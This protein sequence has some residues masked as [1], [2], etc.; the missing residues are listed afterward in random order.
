MAEKNLKLTTKASR[1]PL[2]WLQRLNFDIDSHLN[3]YIPT[4]ISSILPRPVSFFLGYRNHD[5]EIPPDIGNIA[6]AITGAIST[7][8]GLTLIAALFKF[9]P[10]LAAIHPPVLVGSIVSLPLLH[11]S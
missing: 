11:R 9:S 7:F 8:A 2:L 6:I 3:P 4:P 10:S 5:R 1:Y